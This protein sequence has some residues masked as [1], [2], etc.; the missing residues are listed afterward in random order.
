MLLRA[1]PKVS[2]EEVV[3]GFLVRG[4]GMH[5]ELYI[6][7]FSQGRKKP[8]KVRLKRAK[9]NKDLSS[10]ISKGPGPLKIPGE[11]TSKSPISSLPPLTHLGHSE[12]VILLLLSM[13][14]LLAPT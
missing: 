11:N 14:L 9:A 4:R 5:K 10:V 13:V 7:T 8:L 1:R 3:M 2:E 6:H 12:V